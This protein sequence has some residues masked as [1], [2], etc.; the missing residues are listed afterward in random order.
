MAGKAG[1]EI[2]TLLRGRPTPVG[3]TSTKQLTRLP[4]SEVY[5]DLPGRNAFSNLD[6]GLI[7]IDDA[8][9]WSSEIVPPIGA[10]GDLV[11]LNVSTQS[12]QLIDKK[13]EAVGSASGHLRGRI[14]GLFYRYKTMAGIDF[15]TDFLIAPDEGLQTRLGDSGTV[16]VISSDPNDGT[17]TLPRPL[18]VQ[19]GAQSFSEGEEQ[20]Q[21][22]FALASSLNN[23][24]LLLDV[25]VLQSHN[26]GASVTWGSTGH[27]TIAAYACD[28]IQSPEL[29]TLMLANKGNISFDNTGGALDPHT[30]VEKLRAA[31]QNGDF[32]PLADVP[33][34]IWKNNPKDVSGG[35]DTE[36]GGHGWTGPEHPNHF[37]DVDEPLPAGNPDA[38]QTMLTLSANPSYFTL[39]N[40]QKYFNDLG[41]TEKG[42][43]GLL[44]F[45]VW[46]IYKTM[47]KFLQ[48]Q[49]VTSFVG[50]AGILS[51][52][53]GDACQPLHSSYHSDGYREQATSAVTHKRD[54]TQGTKRVWPGQGVHSAYEDKMVDKFHDR[55]YQ[56]IVDLG[57]PTQEATVHGGQAAGA[58]I[59]ELM[60]QTQL[61]LPPDKI[62]EA[63]IKAGGKP[64]LKTF[65]ALFSTC[66]NETAKLWLMG[67]SRLATLWESAWHEG[68]GN[69]IPKAKLVSC[70]TKDLQ[71]LYED[72]DFLPSRYLSQIGLEL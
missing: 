25:E 67:A 21:M 59:V 31:K 46:Q 1:D 52:Y 40:W 50:A 6:I 60:R 63:Y 8:T 34:T 11:D 3:L 47:I 22:Q 2:K 24:C 35:R 30:I 68:G 17:T 45:R 70:K 5:P 38:G 7:E 48:A 57:T 10:I 66:G 54:G 28:L 27:Y 71:A 69:E 37:A 32:C 65:M 72:A 53:I 18:A 61:A 23:I 12:L 19:W 13:V 9:F 14:L 58:M 33:D 4:F 42:S 29:K 51:H 62:I 56:K 64:N 55:L 41:H 43:Q 15:I 26:I 49:D 44:P 16:W 39:A 36:H 20:S